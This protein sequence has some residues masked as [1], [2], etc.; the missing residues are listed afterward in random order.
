M[1]TSLEKEMEAAQRRTNYGRLRRFSLA[2]VGCFH[3]CLLFKVHNVSDQIQHRLDSI[4]TGFEVPYI[5]GQNTTS[6][7]ETFENQSVSSDIVAKEEPTEGDEIVKVFLESQM[8]NYTFDNN[9]WIHF[10]HVG[11]AGGSALY[12][13]FQLERRNSQR[14]SC[15]MNLEED[16]DRGKCHVNLPQTEIQRRTLERYHVGAPGQQKE[17]KAWLKENTNLA[18]FTVRFPTARA[19]SAFNFHFQSMLTKK[20]N[21]GVKS[22]FYSCFDTVEELAL[23][24]SAVDHWKNLTDTCRRTG[25][26]FLR[27]EIYNPG[28]H[29][30]FNYRRYVG[31]VWKPNKAIAVLR[32]EHQEKDTLALEARLGGSPEK[33]GGFEKSSV[34]GTF[35]RQ[36]G[37][38]PMGK[39]SVCCMIYDEISIFSKLVLLS[40]N[41]EHDDKI[42]YLRR[43]MDE[44][45]I[46]PHVDVEHFSW[47]RWYEEKCPRIPY[48][49]GFT[50]IV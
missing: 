16:E 44:C 43:N 30:F 36:S 29:M 8:V 6:M 37:L 38:S 22:E 9:T 20:A 14:V 19:V 18:L 2:A 7:A 5:S 3:L 47:R 50:A 12:N 4:D 46:D 41:L 15:L 17:E 27:G 13:K 25:L 45:G 33:V 42:Q 34:S 39:V 35:A 49:G 24:F 32:L 40:V 48:P 28:K 21:K 31:F 11:K 26:G 23:A 1:R 10:I